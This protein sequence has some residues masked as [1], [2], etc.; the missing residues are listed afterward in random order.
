[1]KKSKVFRGLATTFSSAFAIAISASALAITYGPVINS[2]LSIT[3][4]K[5][6]SK[7]GTTGEIYFKSEFGEMNEKNLDKLV[8]ATREQT[9]QEEAEGAVL[10]YNKEKALPLVSSERG[11]TFFGKAS[12]NFVNIKPG[13]CPKLQEPITLQDALNKYNFRVNKTLWEAYENDTSTPERN[14]L[15]GEIGEASSD[16]YTEKIK[17]SWMKSNEYTDVAF[18]VLARESS[19]GSDLLAEDKDGISALALHDREKDLLKMIKD[20]GRFSKTVVLL[21]TGAPMEVDWLYDEQYGVDACL[22]IGTTGETGMQAV[23]DIL[24]GEVNPSGHTVDTYAT[25]SLSAPAM[26]ASCSRTQRWENLEEMKDSKYITDNIDG[27]RSYVL[28]SEGIYTGYKYYETRYED[29]ILNPDYGATS[30]RGSSD[31]QAWNYDKEMTFPFGHGLSYTTFEQTLLSVNPVGE[32]TM[33]MK[34][35]VKN[36]GDVAGKSVVQVYSQTPYGEY[37]KTNYVEKSAVN[38]I[39]FAKTKLLEPNEEETLTISVDKYLMASYDWYKAK[40]YIMSEGNYYLSIG[41]DAHDALNNILAAKGATG[42]IDTRGNPV[43]GNE[44]K[45]YSWH[46][47]FDDK[48]YSKSST[49]YPVTNQFDDCNILYF[50]PDKKVEDFYITRQHWD[51]SYPEA[52]IRLKATDEMMKYLNNYFYQKAEDAPSAAT[53]IQGDYKGI[54]LVDMMGVPYS[55][56]YIDKNGVEQDGEKRWDE[57]ISQFTY[58]DLALALC[59]GAGTKEIAKFIKPATKHGDGMDGNGNGVFK[60]QYHGKR[61]TAN[62]YTAKVVLTAT[63]NR[64]IYK[65]RGELMGEECLWNGMQTIFGIGG[66]FHRNAFGGRNPEYMAEDP[67]L[68]YHASIPEVDGYA[69]KGVLA[70]IKHFAGNTQETDRGGVSMLFTEQSWREADLRAFEGCLRKSGNG[71]G[72]M[73]GLNRVG[74]RY[75]PTVEA[76]HTTVLR[77][78][79]GFV[80]TTETDGCQGLNFKT[81]WAD[82]VHAGTSV[83]CLDSTGV[84]GKS[85]VAAIK[86]NDDGTLLNDLRRA[87]KDYFWVSANSCT[88]NGLSNDVVVKSITPWWKTIIYVANPII[89]VLAI[90]SMVG[91]FL[92]K[93]SKEEKNH[94]DADKK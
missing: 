27:L 8:Q 48:T 72:L 36:T 37:E 31:G 93:F 15:T 46:E 53:I 58:D 70:S 34:V 65:R 40:T 89:G 28:E 23:V 11:V 83:Y 10:L 88:M 90:G 4:S 66:N 76:M 52:P 60:F 87:V 81:H 41:E 13:T 82:M 45:V 29:S 84:S 63:F 44:T 85:I 59:D 49:G 20:S 68:C 50:Y 24:V 14:D 94:A 47:D 92:C 16:F 62:Q 17:D 19:E 39:D 71:H 74:L 57:F 5:V 51:T 80:G 79:W 35:K 22:W 77:K 12:T 69:S 25:N 1:M 67:I 21:N 9:Y 43:E 2:Q 18:V 32:D 55:G 26:I 42:M 56:K 61:R 86:K 33:E 91:Y 73:Q 78:E 7:A 6:V 38:F 64:D 30:K 54:T 3:T 75:G